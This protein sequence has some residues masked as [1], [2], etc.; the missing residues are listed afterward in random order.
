MARLSQKREAGENGARVS[1]WPREALC[2]TKALLFIESIFK[3]RG[4]LRAP[5][6]KHWSYRILALRS[7]SMHEEEH[8]RI[9]ELCAGLQRSANARAV[10]LV[11]RNGQFITSHGEV[12]DLDMTSLASLTAGNMAATG[13]LARLMGEKEFPN[14]FHE[15]ERDHLHLSS[16]G[17]RA[18]LVVMFDRRSSL[19]LVR[20]RVRQTTALLSAVFKDMQAR[21][22]QNAQASPL[23][24]V[25][26]AEIDNLFK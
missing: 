19:G 11:D 12:E 22:S 3:S 17:K 1:S 24:D 15:G 20:L 5:E 4:S 9:A 7:T 21:S 6:S 10:M 25:T 13:G 14:I 18:I 23:A 2:C 8:H 26:D 16:V